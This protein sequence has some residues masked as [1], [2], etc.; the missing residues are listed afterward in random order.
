[1]AVSSSI[2]EGSLYF[3]PMPV[4]FASEQLVEAAIR[5]VASGGP[6]AAGATAVARAVGAPSGS[7]YHRFATRR[8]LLAAAWLSPV[9]HFQDGF[10]PFLTAD[11][12]TAGDPVAAGVAAAR[13]VVEWSARNPQAA[14]VLARYGRADLVADDCAPAILAEAD[15]LEVRLND[16]LTQFIGRF[17][18]ADRARI[19][20]AVVDAPLAL[21]RR[22]LAAAGVPTVAVEL[23]GEIAATLLSGHSGDQ[24]DELS[25]GGR[26]QQA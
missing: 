25:R 18:T 17:P 7:V 3:V 26:E 20:M 21:V 12:D 1:M 6:D 24:G 5:L 2:V 11:D 4:K 22:H 13:H 8:D 23:A 10:L 9:R 19:L 14:T 15:E 16:A